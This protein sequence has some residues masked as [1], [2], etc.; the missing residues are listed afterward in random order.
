MREDAD[1]GKQNE[2]DSC[3]STSIGDEGGSS[4]QDAVIAESCKDL[5]GKSK[6]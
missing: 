2:P 5:V 1:A 6:Y 4:E 3:I